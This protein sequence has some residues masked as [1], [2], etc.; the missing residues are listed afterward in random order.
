MLQKLSDVVQFDCD[1]EMVDKAYLLFS[2]REYFYREA[3]KTAQS[4][5]GK[6]FCEGQRIAYKAAMEKMTEFLREMN[7]ENRQLTASTAYMGGRGVVL[8]PLVLV[9]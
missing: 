2:R 3:E 9:A 6:S 1:Y 8:R 4:E 5:A 7:R